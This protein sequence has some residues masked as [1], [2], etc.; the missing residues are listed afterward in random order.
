MILH[1]CQIIYW[2]LVQARVWRHLIDKTTRVWSDYVLVG[3]NSSFPMS[4]KSGRVI[5]CTAPQLYP[6]WELDFTHLRIPPWQLEPKLFNFFCRVVLLRSLAGQPATC[7]W[8]WPPVHLLHVLYML[9][10]LSSD[11][12]PRRLNY[13]YKRFCYTICYHNLV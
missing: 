8:Q 9:Y 7:G 5:D 4:L 6:K 1:S 12:F 10:L 13:F 11:P 3:S 2:V